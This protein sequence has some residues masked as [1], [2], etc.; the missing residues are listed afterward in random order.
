MRAVQITRFG[1][2]EVLEVV[3]VPDPVAADGLQVLEVSSA[4]VNY[5]DTHQVEDSYLSKT[6][7]PLVPGSE[8]VGTLP[9]GTRVA[10]FATGGSYAEKALVHPAMSFPLPDGV[11]DGQ[12]L[13]LMVQGLT[14]WHLLRTSTHLQAGESVV[15]HA[16]AGGVGTL[17]VQLAKA[18]GAG[19]V[20]GVASSPDK[21]ELAA[22]LGADVTVDAGVDDLKSALEQANGG[23]KVDVVLEMVGGSTFAA[24][25]AALAPFGRL[26]TFGMASREAAKPVHSGELMSRSRAVVGFWLAHCFARPDMLQ[27][28]MAELLSMVESGRLTPVVGGTYPLSEARRAHED[29]RSRASQGKLVLDALS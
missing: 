12:A 6:E 23:R 26:A 15:V 22:S 11:T 9:D 8:V 24:S 13:S 27:P 17:A 16:A 20:I 10:A 18:W 5:A 4:G 21:R 1:G 25:L 7:L 19:T 2:P 14:A 29:L 28:Q 3:E